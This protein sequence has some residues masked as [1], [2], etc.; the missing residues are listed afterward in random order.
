MG[1]YYEKWKQL[2]RKPVTWLLFLMPIAASVGFGMLFTKQQTELTIPIVIVDEDQSSTSDAVIQGL[3]SQT[4]LTVKEMPASAA[5]KQ[6]LQGEVDSVF[7][8]KKHFQTELRK[9]KRDGLIELW[10][11]PS[12]VAAGIVREIA[13]SEIIKQTSAAKAANK[14]VSL[15]KQKYEDQGERSEI[16]QQA[17]DYTMDQWQPE[18]LMTIQYKIGSDKRQDTNKEKATLLFSP[19][20]GLWSFFTMLSCFIFS[21]WAVK[22][23]WTIFPRIRASSIGLPAYLSQCAAAHLIIQLIQAGFAFVVFRYLNVINGGIVVFS[24][25]AVFVLFSTVIGLL[26]AVFHT[27]AGPFYLTALSTALLFALFGGSFFPAGELFS[28][29]QKLSEMFPQTALAA[30]ENKDRLTDPLVWESVF[31]MAAVVLISWPLIVW[32]AGREYD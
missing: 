25:M 24:V 30:A 1:I 29:I 27:H 32:K 11:S 4:G 14:V 20:L 28:F 26:L 16:W 13:A 3:K 21:D 19:Y 9:G 2:M 6:L 22:E 12:S 23:R 17:Y 10:T 7:I 5:K 8:I 15:Y 18:P 31:A